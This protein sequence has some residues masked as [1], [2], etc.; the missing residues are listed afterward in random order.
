MR[1][2]RFPAL[3]KAIVYFDPSSGVSTA[4]PPP[5]NLT[6]CQDVPASGDPADR[7][8]CEVAGCGFRGGCQDDEQGER[9]RTEPGK[10]VQE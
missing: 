4:P 9:R 6:S 5:W 1:A 10:A 3:S 2:D 7:G 8:C